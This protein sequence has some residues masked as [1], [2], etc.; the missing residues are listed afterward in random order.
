[1]NNNTT[2]PKSELH[3]HKRSGLP[4]DC[5]FLV[6]K[7][8]KESWEA[9]QNLGESSKFWLSR[10]EMF[11][12]LS[13]I[14]LQSASELKEQ[15]LK[16]AEFRNWFVPR[17]WFFIQQLDAHHRIED[18]HYFPLLIRAEEKLKA[19]FELLE[20]DHGV[21]HDGLLR[22]QDAGLKL[23]QALQHD[24][25]RILFITDDVAKELTAFLGDLTRHLADEEDLV[26]P[27]ILDRTEASI[28][29]M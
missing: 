25:S 1:M 22:L 2:A 20:N 5:A 7:Y 4:D 3:L 19:G 10:H 16:P 6:K 21:I 23:D 28:G 14:L 9:H 15:E 8:P 27:L 17:Y 13:T 29:L 11:R 18:G 12:E 24:P 26:I